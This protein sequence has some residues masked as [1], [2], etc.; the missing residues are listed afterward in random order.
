MHIGI[1]CDPPFITHSCAIV[2]SQ[3]A[4]QLV[5]QGHKVSYLGYNYQG[6]VI[7][8]KDGYKIYPDTFPCTTEASIVAF[9]RETKVEAIYAHGSKDIFRGCIEGCKQ[10][11]IPFIPHTFFNSG[12]LTNNNIKNFEVQNK[13]ALADLENVDKVLTCNKFSLGVF[14]ALNKKSWYLP[15]GVDTT[16]FYP[17]RV[18]NF[19]E[20][21]GI[22]DK[23]VV[24]FVG[25]NSE[26]KDPITAIDSF[27]NI[28]KVFIDNCVMVL[29]TRPDNGKTN[30]K[31][32]IEET[33]PTIKNKFYFLS[34][35]RPEW[36]TE[37]ETGYNYTACSPA[38]LHTSYE[39]MPKVYN[40]G[41]V[42]IV[43]SLA[44]GMSTTMLEGL[45]CGVPIICSDDPVISEIITNGVNGIL[46]PRNPDNSCIKEYV[47]TAI[48]DIYLSKDIYY[49]SNKIKAEFSWELIAKNLIKLITNVWMKKDL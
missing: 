49:T 41:D 7:D 24:L 31:K 34:D 17:S 40:T 4:K 2:G 42:Q 45:A 14:S 21:L 11:N 27:A 44:E 6:L 1:V 38:Y 46:V 25:T 37:K 12:E 9:I 39:D 13:F 32:Y 33:Y 29:H 43:T 35:Y 22:E 20:Q 47:T 3:I 10:Q 16:L 15:N 8:H 23:F 48:E 28:N 5:K 26:G 18:N 30:L 36:L 19:R